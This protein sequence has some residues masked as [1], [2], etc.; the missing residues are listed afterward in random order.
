MRQNSFIALITCALMGALSLPASQ[1][2][3]LPFAK[4]LRFGTDK[5]VEFAVQLTRHR[6]YFIDV[7]FYF[8]DDTQRT[9]AKKI[10]GEP[11]RICKALNDCGVT[12]SFLVTIKSADNT[13]SSEEKTPTGQYAF[14]ANQY[15]RHISIGPLRPGTYTITVEVTHSTDQLKQIPAD[16]ELTT[17]A[18]ASDIVE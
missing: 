11:T 17:D 15:S 9:V 8:E 10:A 2:T 6:A 5:S 3:G 18:R 13:V 1:A 14:S 4:P 7:V 12:P 16:I